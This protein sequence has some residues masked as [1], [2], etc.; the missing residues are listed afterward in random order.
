MDLLGLISHTVTSHTRNLELHKRLLTSQHDLL[1]L[2]SG[3]AAS[4]PISKFL[5]EHQLFV[6][7]LNFMNVQQ[8]QLIQL[9]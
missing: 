6:G 5:K 4:N 3:A 1:F 2:E 8:F 9:Q 7:A